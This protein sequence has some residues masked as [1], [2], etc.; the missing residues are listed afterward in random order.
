MIETSPSPIDDGPVTR[1][2]YASTGCSTGKDSIRNGPTATVIVVGVFGVIAALLLLGDTVLLSAVLSALLNML[3]TVFTT[4]FQLLSLLLLM[5]LSLLPFSRQALPQ[6]P[7]AQAA[8]AAPPAPLPTKKVLTVDAD[9][10]TIP[11]MAGDPFQVALDTDAGA[12]YLWTLLERRWQ[13][14]A[15]ALGL[16]LESTH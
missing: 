8:A 6:P 9:G 2:A 7:P 13:P 14:Y 1:T 4:L 12:G 15:G 11:V 16:A 10:Q 3:F 5:L